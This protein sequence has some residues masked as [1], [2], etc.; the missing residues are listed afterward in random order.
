MVNS[1]KIYKVLVYTAI[2]VIISFS[3]IY[4]YI[5]SNYPTNN[6]STFTKKR[7]LLIASVY[8]NPYWQRIKNGAED[9]ANNRGCY[10]EYAGPQTLN[11][12][13]GLKIIDMGIATSVDGIITSVQE[14][15]QYLPAIKKATDIGIPV[16]TV[17]TDANLSERIAYVG[18]NNIEAG[19]S[20][21]EELADI[22]LTNAKIGIIMAGETNTSQVER[23]KGFKD[24]IS[25]YPDMKVVAVESSNSDVIQ[26]ELAANK[27]MASHPEMDTLYCT[28]SVDGIGAARAVVDRNKVGKVNIVCFDDLPETLQ[29]IKDG[30]IQAS[31][32]QKPY[33]MGYDSVS[34]MMDKLEGLKVNEVNL[35]GILI[36]R[37]DNVYN[38]NI[39]KGEMN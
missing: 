19:T 34:L 15:K 30:V 33:Q 1:M 17:D 32:V 3:V 23:V 12:S 2:F 22:S 28:S 25:N 9:A 31:V 4:S 39:E 16:I 29:F 35:M 37:K 21:A 20:A 18:T 5:F 36:V 7:I 6:A 24:Y 11:M 26:A 13:E 38:Y 27:M 14:E 10:I 8:Q